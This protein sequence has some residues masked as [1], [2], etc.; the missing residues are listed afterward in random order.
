M[1]CVL[2]DERT[3]KA[4][5]TYDDSICFV[6]PACGRCGDPV[7]VW[8]RHGRAPTDWE[9]DHMKAKLLLYAGGKEFNLMSGEVDADA[10]EFSGHWHAHLRMGGGPAGGS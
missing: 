5:R 10:K 2:C 9:K 4:K 1:S 6:S 8:R 7:V 3:R